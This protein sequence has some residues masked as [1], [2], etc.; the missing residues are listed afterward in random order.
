MN[1]K[2]RRVQQA[3]AKPVAPPPAPQP[4][5]IDQL[6]QRGL[7]YIQSNDLN[8]ARFV[9]QKVLELDPKDIWGRMVYADLIGDGSH[10]KCAESRDLLLSVLDDHPSIYDHPTEDNLRLIRSA[11][12][13]CAQVGP[14]ARAIE[15]FRKL[16]HASN[17]ASDYFQLSEILTQGNFFEES[18]S[19]LEKAIAL[20]PAAYDTAT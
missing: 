19:S 17:A 8:G 15:L 10:K 13:K 12:Q 18:L 16:A 20:D 14:F 6:K 11:A 5:L 9:F 3:T 7:Q 1:R 4:S 2:A